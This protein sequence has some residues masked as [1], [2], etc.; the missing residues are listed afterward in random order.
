VGLDWPQTDAD[1]RIDRAL[2]SFAGCKE[3][4]PQGLKPYFAARE[5]A[6]AEALAY[7]EAKTTTTLWLVERFA[8]PPILPCSEAGW[9]LI[10]NFAMDWTSGRVVPR[11]W[12]KSRF[13]RCAD[14]IVREQLRSK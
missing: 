2:E 7:L 10:A 14:H 12:W 8:I 11:A 5:S 6:K 13:L 4:I 1:V 3:G 9:D